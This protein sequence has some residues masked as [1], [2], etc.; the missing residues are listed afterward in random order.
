MP[1]K[2]LESFLSYLRNER[3][4]SEHTAQSYRMDIEQFARMVLKKD[5]RENPESVNWNDV[6]VFS[7]RLF[8][9]ELQ[10]ND[11]TKTSTLRKI[12]SLRSFFRFMVREELVKQNPFSGLTSP[13]KEKRLPKYMSVDEVGKLLDAP[14]IF[15]KE[16]KDNKTSKDDDSANFA[17]AR[18]SAILEV[19][20]SGGLR[21]SEALGL[22][23]GDVDLISDIIK[24]KGKGKKERIAALGKPASMSLSSYFKIREIRNASANQGSPVFVNK[25]GTRIS[26]RSF[27]RNFKQY[28][29]TAGLPADMTPHKLRHSFATHMLNAGADM[30]SV[31]ELLGHANLSTTQIYTHVTA[32]RLKVEYSK[33][34]PR[35]K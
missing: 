20:Y 18:D 35:A 34:H 10:K 25:D 30:R 16:A 9:M 33:A 21:I 23:M 5:I 13:K 11:I 32:E 19:I 2:Q 24:V 3:Q 31:Q 14:A 6:S 1:N 7:A 27:Q 26:S 22:N 12:S 28:L 4:S 17:A 29:A 8:V 15:W